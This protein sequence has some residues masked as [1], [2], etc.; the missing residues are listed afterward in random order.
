MSWRIKVELVNGKIKESDPSL[1]LSREQFIRI[2]S[3]LVRE[4]NVKRLTLI[5]SNGEEKIL[6]Q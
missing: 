2:S 1:P 6:K 3:K 4:P 5:N